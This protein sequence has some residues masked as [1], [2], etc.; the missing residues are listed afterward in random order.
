MCALA[1]ER[2]KRI[3]GSEWA[4]I[5]TL[6]VQLYLDER[7]AYARAQAAQQV[8]VLKGFFRVLGF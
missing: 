6:E 2:R 3:E 7:E 8:R 4:L 5:D 1:T